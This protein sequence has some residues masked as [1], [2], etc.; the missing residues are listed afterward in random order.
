[1]SYA[2]PPPAVLVDYPF[3]TLP[4]NAALQLLAANPRRL[5]WAIHSRSGNGNGA[6]AQVRYGSTN[7]IGLAKGGVLQNGETVRVETQS[8][9]F[10]FAGTAGQVVAVQELV[11]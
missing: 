8:T 3:V 9:L 10:A 7:T 11:R 5:W 6:N 2:L 4:A 1:M